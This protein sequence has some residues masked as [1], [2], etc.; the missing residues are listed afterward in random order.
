MN[1]NRRHM[2][3][4][5]L[6]PSVRRAT[7]LVRAVDAILGTHRRKGRLQEKRHA[8]ATRMSSR[9]DDYL[10][11][12]RDLRVPFDNNEAERVIRMSK[13]RIKVS[14][15]MRSLAG[16]EAFCA[17]RSYLATATR[18]GTGWLEALTQALDGNPWIPGTALASPHCTAWR[19]W[20]GPGA[21]LNREVAGVARIGALPQGLG[22]ADPQSSRGGQSDLPA[23]VAGEELRAS[24]ADRD[25]VVELLGVAAGDGRLSPE[26][27]DDRLERALTART[28]AELAALTADLPATPGAA[29]VPPGAGAVSATPKDL[30][31]IHVH[32]S[33]VRRDGRWVVP[34]ELDV[35]VRGGGVTLDFTEA[36][37]TQP[38]L[39]ITAEVRGGGLRLITRPGI[40]V[41]AD[42]ISVHGGSVT[43]PKPPGPGVP[44]LLRVEIAGSV[45]GAGITAGPPPPPRRPRRTFWQWLRRAPRRPAIAA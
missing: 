3:G 35:K 21:A 37:I 38:L 29:V 8:L 2:T 25:Q 41:D 43:L 28:Y 10:R 23:T 19:T 11:Y 40:V 6:G 33:S 26:E 12:A 32:G 45:R 14:G 13:L 9:A 4:D 31:R 30:A 36:V 5:H 24:H 22:M 34:K 7:L 17:I 44:V 27:L 39:R 1:T 15:S 42:D 18:H 16:A 20:R